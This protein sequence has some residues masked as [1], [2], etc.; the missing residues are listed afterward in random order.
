M[1]DVAQTFAYYFKMGAGTELFVHNETLFRQMVTRSREIQ[2]YNK[3]GGNAPV[4]AE[5]AFM[6]GANV[7]LGA[8]VTE[9]WYEQHYNSSEMVELAVPIGP[10]KDIHLMLEY[11]GIQKWGSLETPRGNRFYLNHDVDN[12]DFL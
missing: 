10:L 8:V 12:A 2:V 9:E 3:L 6:E 1:E 5:R 4:M 7:L 11:D